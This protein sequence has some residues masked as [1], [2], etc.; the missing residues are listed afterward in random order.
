MVNPDNNE[1]TRVAG[2]E[3]QATADVWRG[4]KPAGVFANAEALA[5]DNTKKDYP[6]WVDQY[7]TGTMAG[8][9]ALEVTRNAAVN[10]QSASDAWRGVKPGDV[11][12]TLDQK[13]D[14]DYVNEYDAKV[15][16]SP[17]QYEAGRV[18]AV[19]AQKTADVWRGVKPLGFAQHADH[20]DYPDHL[21]EQ[22]T[23]TTTTSTNLEDTR[24]AAID[25]TAA[26][27]VWRG[28]K[29]VGVFNGALVQ[30]H[31]DYPEHLGE[32]RLRTDNTSA[33]LEATRQEAVS[34]Q[35]ADDVWRGKSLSQHADQ[36][37]YPVWVNEYNKATLDNADSIERI[38]SAA[39]DS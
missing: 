27:N 9:N 34:D 35:A 13:N 25:G 19:E 14:R 4:V 18:A 36:K 5:Q 30:D 16:G 21:G 8:P 17:D 3:A 6:E 10:K 32:Q 28:V 33:A 26:S 24:Q 22:N 39:V 15:Y 23:V 37:D 1:A 20:K 31:K 2:V 12:Q 11:F 7:H 29:P 38:R